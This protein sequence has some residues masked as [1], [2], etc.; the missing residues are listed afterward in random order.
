MRIPATKVFLALVLLLLLVPVGSLTLPSQLASASSGASAQNFSSSSHTTA[1][2]PIYTKIPITIPRVITQA[3]SLGEI[4]PN[5]AISFD[6][7]LPPKD[8]QGLSQLLSKVYNPSSNLYHHF[9]TQQQY[10]FFYGPDTSEAALISSYLSSSG[11]KSTLESSGLLS[12]SGSAINIERALNVSIDSF[13]L[14]KTT[15]Y[16]ATSYPKLPSAFSNILGIYGLQNYEPPTRSAV[17]LYRTLGQVIKPGQ[18]LGNFLYYSPAEIRQAYN[19]S[20][21]INEGYNGSGVSIAIID[22]YGDPYIQQELNNFSA[23]FNL[24]QTTINQICV[25]GPCDYSQGISQGWNTEIALDVEWAHAMAPGATINLYI[26]S[27]SSQPLFDAVE[28]A[29]SSGKNSIISMSWGSPENTY[30]A[31]SPYAP[32]F[33]QSYPWLDQVLQQSAAEGITAFASSGD[34]GAYDQGF[35]QTASYGGATYPS[36]DPYVTGVGGTSLY[37]NTTRGYLQFPYYNANG[38][39]GSETAWSWNNAYGWGTGGGYST[40]FPQPSWQQGQGVNTNGSRGSPDVSWDADVQTG[41]AVSLY[42][43]S[44]SSYNYYIVGGTS[45]G[46][47]SWAGSIALIEQ[48]AGARLGL[49]NPEIYSILQNKQEYS[50][51]F[52]DVTVGNNN[53]LN[54][55][56]GWDPL[57][58]VGTPNLGELANYLAPSGSISVAVQ[59]SLS[60][61]LDSSYSYSSAV[62]ISAVVNGPSGTIAS[63]T[64]SATITSGN[65]VVASNVPMVYNT[66]TGTWQGAYQIKHGDPPGEWTATVNA[67]SGSL[68]GVGSTTFSVGDGITMFMPFYNIKTAAQLSHF[69]LTGQQVNISAAITSP[70]GSSIISSGNYSAI[71]YLGG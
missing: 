4:S 44:T 62:G 20:S 68:S 28:M 3:K 42:D 16:S 46:S 49:L 47:P 22:A 29:V 39:Y 58:G 17:P 25:D 15:F 2:N 11:L 8:P 1:L 43:Q 34:W 26:G 56:P 71:F 27:N 64:V 32:I 65:V 53:P 48:K 63:G 45:V 59:N 18:S 31:S 23:E 40:L 50:K 41:V 19:S 12:V 13:Q 5:T 54:A 6:I 33:G 70:D 14:G 21:L 66:F 52:H 61:K 60:G 57:T 7:L 51:A 36:T 55:G 67:Q 10:E 9:L 30:A 37:L 69:F 24:P 38:T 35:G